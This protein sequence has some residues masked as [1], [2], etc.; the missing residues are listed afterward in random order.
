[1]NQVADICTQFAVGNPVSIT[2]LSGG[3]VHTTYKVVTD[4]G[5]YILQRM[6]PIFNPS[7][8]CLNVHAVTERLRAYGFETYTLVTTK[9]G[10]CTH[11]D[12]QFHWRVLTFLEGRIVSNGG[13]LD[14]V[15]SAGNLIGTFHDALRDFSGGV[16][17]PL[18]GYHDTERYMEKL[19]RVDTTSYGTQKYELLHASAQEILNAYEALD[20]AVCHSS[21]RT[22]HGDPQIENVMFRTGTKEAFT[23][24]DLDTV[25]TYPIATEIG[26]VGWS[27]TKELTSSGAIVA[28]DRWYAVFEGYRSSARTLTT[29]EWS[30][31]PDMCVLATLE[32]RA[33]YIT[34]AY[35]EQYYVLD[36]KR[37]DS[38]FEQNI[39]RDRELSQFLADFVSKR[40]EIEKLHRQSLVL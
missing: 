5:T 4:G 8:V 38:L 33:R 15:R 27:W 39:L 24:I 13:D 10:A 12:G 11:F 20:H 37:Y 19:R 32:Q 35:E 14:E 7:V 2:E 30:L 6:N 3:L 16:G 17:H 9:T 28:Q 23:M 36:R 1:M 29:D 40:P 18:P 34:D 21:V 25:W 26:F 22:F 31:F